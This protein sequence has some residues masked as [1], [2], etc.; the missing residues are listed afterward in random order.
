MRMHTKME[1]NMLNS[2][3]IILMTKLA[4]YEEQ[5]KNKSIIKSK[6]YKDDYIGLGL[7]NS[8]IV[9]TLAYVLFIAVIV[10]VNIEEVVASLPTYDFMKLG[11]IILVSYIV[12]MIVYLVISYVI[13]KIKYSQI[14]S[15]LKEYDSNLKMLYQLYKEEGKRNVEES[16]SIES[17]RDFVEDYDEISMADMEE[18]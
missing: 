7:L 14:S 11:R 10:F 15:E 13:Y 3:R 12:Y 6:Y 5:K 9:A 17:E 1:V 8:G 16:E 4:L 18:E 2:D